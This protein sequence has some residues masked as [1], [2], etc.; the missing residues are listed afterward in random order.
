MSNEPD[1][2]ELYQLP[3][4]LQD[5]SDSEEVDYGTMTAFQQEAIDEMVAIAAEAKSY[6]P[7]VKLTQPNSKVLNEEN[8]AHK[9]GHF[10][11]E[12]EAIGNEFIAILLAVRA[13]AT[14]FAEVGGGIEHVYDMKDPRFQQWLSIGGKRHQVGP[15]YLVWLPELKKFARIHLYGTSAQNIGDFTVNND[16]PKLVYSK[17]IDK[18]EYTWWVIQARTATDASGNPL[19]RNALPKPKRSALKKQQERF[20]NPHLYDDPDSDSEE[21]KEVPSTG[22]SSPTSLDR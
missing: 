10:N 4:A 8:T 5:D 18:P 7:I 12:G 9:R 6:T 21:I 1:A 20:R 16:K 14:R 17:K 13:R 22:R 3:A 15:E 2:N 19:D 11:L